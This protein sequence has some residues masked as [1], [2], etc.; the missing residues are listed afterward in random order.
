MSD[1]FPIRIWDARDFLV[2][3]YR[4]EI[5]LQELASIAGCSEFHFHRLYS[6][7]FGETP[8]QAITRWRVREAETLLR[9]SGVTVQE[10]CLDVGFSSLSS[11]THLFKRYTGV[12]PAE[13]RRVFAIP[14]LY[15]LK[16]MPACFLKA[17]S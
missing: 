14:E 15:A 16:V 2:G 8:H 6:Q 5:R 3:N 9:H 10:V 4:A 7:T 17:A 12:S 1:D 13:Y 11:F